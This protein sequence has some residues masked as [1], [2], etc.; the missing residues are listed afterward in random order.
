MLGKPVEVI[1]FE[2]VLDVGVY[3]A[4][5]STDTGE[6]GQGALCAQPLSLNCLKRDLFAPINKLVTEPGPQHSKWTGLKEID[7]DL[8]I[9]GG[10]LQT[11]KRSQTTNP[12]RIEDIF[13][14]QTVPKVALFNFRLI[15]DNH[16]LTIFIGCK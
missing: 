12:H 15:F 10:S 11:K 9:W 14:L 5:F 3:V 8:G 1:S 2:S 13:F 16:Q 7:L 4:Q 6:T